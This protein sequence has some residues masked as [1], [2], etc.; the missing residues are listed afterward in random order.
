[1]ADDEAIR[2]LTGLVFDGTFEST[3]VKELRV[4]ILDAVELVA[5]EDG[6]VAGASCDGAHH[7]L[8]FPPCGERHAGLDQRAGAGRRRARRRRMM[9]Y[10]PAF[11]F[12]F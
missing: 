2:R 6:S 5:V 10:A 12:A 7:R 4:A 8:P 9:A 3:L 11:R 1:M